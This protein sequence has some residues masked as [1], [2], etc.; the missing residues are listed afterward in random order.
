MNRIQLAA[1][2]LKSVAKLMDMISD[3]DAPADHLWMCIRGGR[4]YVRAI[5]S[6]D[7]A[8]DDVVNQRRTACALC[9]L[10]T[11]ES[12]G[13]EVTSNWCGVR[14]EDN[15]DIEGGCGCLIEGKT[16]VASEECPHG[17]WGPVEITVGATSWQQ[18]S[19][20]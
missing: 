8:P 6:N 15:T 3:G 20:R 17:H 16:A 5:V 4:K 19:E 18:C 11:T 13:G 12:H 9:S 7:I 10:R 2:A 14:M 1:L